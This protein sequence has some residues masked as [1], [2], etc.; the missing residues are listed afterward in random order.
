MS[1]RNT[2]ILVSEDCPAKGGVVPGERGGKPTV[3]SLEYELLSS[4]P[5]RFTRDDLLYE[6]HA[7]RTGLPPEA[8]R[9]RGAQIRAELLSKPHP[10]MRA[11][12]LPKTYGWGVHHD[13]EGK[14]GLVPLGS[15]DYAR[16]AKGGDV[17]IVKAMRNKRA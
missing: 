10:C 15:P 6:V 17:T 2:F 3:A 14:I 7:R 9:E 13:A 11:S 1:Y 16:L 5:Y 8:L 4:H 12:P